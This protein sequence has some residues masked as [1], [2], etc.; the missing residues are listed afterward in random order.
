MPS[1][2]ERTRRPLIVYLPGVAWDALAG[3]DRRLVEELAQRAD[4]VWVDPAGSVLRSPDARMPWQWRRVDEPLAGVTRLRTIGPPGVT[5]PGS[6]DL[7]RLAQESALLSLL[8]HRGRPYAVILSDPDRRFPPRVEGRRTLYVTDEWLAGAP[9]MGLP[10]RRVE[11]VLDANLRAADLVL[12]VS[13]TLASDLQAR[14]RGRSVKVLPNGGP[15]VTATP[16]TISGP[17]GAGGPASAGTSARV[18]LVGQLNERLD[19]DLVEEVTRRGIDIVVLG[20]RTDRDPSFGARLSRWLSGPRVDYR[21]MVEPDAVRAT[22][23]G[24]RVG[25]TPY[26]DTPFNRAS[27]P[28]KTLDYLAAGLEVVSS[29]LPASLW[30]DSPDVVV[31]KSVA[32]FADLVVAASRSPADPTSVAR[33][34]ELA[35]RHTWSARADQLLDQLRRLGEL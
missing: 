15:E 29:D 3:T 14:L 26:L 35:R 6:R 9:L 23:S 2:G 13:P 12:A 30:L 34:L 1:P 18:G 5:R 11:A 19:L 20:P 22:M 24:L 8:A 4:V 7:A 16:S 33:R 17:V 25:L 21:G 32:S 10:V 27:F 31:G 28:L